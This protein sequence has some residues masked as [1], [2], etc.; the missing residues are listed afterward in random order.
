M[1]DIMTLLIKDWQLLGNSQHSCDM[2]FIQLL[3][4]LCCKEVANVECTFIRVLEYVVHIRNT[5]DS[6]KELGI[7]VELL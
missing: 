2:V 1:V 5:I 6:F 7:H 3:Y 4:I